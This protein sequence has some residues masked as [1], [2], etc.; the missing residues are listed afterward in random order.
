MPKSI[1]FGIT[2]VAW[3]LAATCPAGAEPAPAAAAIETAGGTVFGSDGKISASLLK[4]IVT[5]LAA[6]FDLPS[7]DALPTVN[8]AAPATIAA[9]RYRGLLGAGERPGNPGAPPEIVAVYDDKQQTI[10][11][12]ND[13]SGKTP[14]ELSVLVHEMVHHLQT[15]MR[16]NFECPQAREKVAYAA[17]QKWLELS[18]RSLAS[19]F[20]L[21]GLTL[22]LTTKCMF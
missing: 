4:S 2:F 20:Q 1:T 9:L 3:A 10:Y 15:Q 13:W 21:D 11:L 6:N 22:L 17:Q 12:Q 5:W 16:T 8:R 18:G 19:E 14:A 7:T